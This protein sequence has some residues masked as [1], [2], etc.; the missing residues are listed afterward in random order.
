VLVEGKESLEAGRSVL[1]FPQSTRSP[2]FDPAVFNSLGVKLAA[3][4]G[5]PVV[6]L[7]LKTDFSGIGPIVKEWGRVD[8]R[9][10]VHFRFGEPLDPSSGGRTTH[11]AVVDFIAGSVREWGGM[12][13]EG[14]AVGAV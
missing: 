10:T 5:V 7:A 14:G 13:A 11:A 12:V 9:K 3:R 8:R 2:V 1:V 4:S 6:P